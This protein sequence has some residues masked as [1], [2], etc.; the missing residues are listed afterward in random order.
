MKQVYRLNPDVYRDLERK[1]LSDIY[2]SKETTDIQAG[3]MLGI[4]KVLKEL[5]DGFT[6]DNS[7]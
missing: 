1:V 4:Q 7:L 2:I 6:I 3:Y 5:R